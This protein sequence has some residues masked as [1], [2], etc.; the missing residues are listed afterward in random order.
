MNTQQCP[1]CNRKATCSTRRVSDPVTV[2]PSPLSVA[3]EECGEFTAE[4]GFFPH[5]WATILPEK[6]RAIAVYLKTTNGLQGCV[7]ELRDREAHSLRPPPSEHQKRG[8]PY[9][10]ARVEQS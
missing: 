7:R 1:V 5:V 9:Y 2:L 10:S 3:C 6:K 4:E 8:L